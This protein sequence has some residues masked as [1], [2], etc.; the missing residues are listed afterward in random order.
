MQKLLG[1]Y[2][3][4][5]LRTG[6]HIQWNNSQV[7]EG[8]PS[9]YF[10]NIQMSRDY[11][12]Y[13]PHDFVL[14]ICQKKTYFQGCLATVGWRKAEKVWFCHCKNYNKLFN[15]LKYSFYVFNI[16][17]FLFSFQV[18]AIVGFIAS[19]L[20]F[21]ALQLIPLADTRVIGSAKPVFVIFAARIFLGEPIGIFPVCAAMMT[22]A[23][24]GIIARPPILTGE[25]KFEMDALVKKR[26]KTL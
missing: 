17:F 19:F 12:T 20:N 10:N 21:Y 16:Y 6:I 23:G 22:A 13:F 5:C 3:Q 11:G 14:Q 1:H 24:V 18:R 26:S 4:H 8:L 15:P 7:L 25:E 9:L 2:A